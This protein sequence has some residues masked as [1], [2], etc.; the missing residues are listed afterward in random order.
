MRFIITLAA[1]LALGLPTSAQQQPTISPSFLAH[2]IDDAVFGMAQ[3]IEQ[4]EQDLA[5]ANNRIKELE[6][7]KK[8]GEGK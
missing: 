3:R 2:Q 5:K 1:L 4:L 7:D 6:A 8:G